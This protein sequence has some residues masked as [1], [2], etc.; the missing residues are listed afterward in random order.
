[1]AGK[2][3]MEKRKAKNLLDGSD[4]DEDIS[5]KINENYAQRYEKWRGKEEIQK[6]T[7]R[8]GENALKLDAPDDEDDSSSTDEDEDAKELT[9]DVEKQFFKTLACL[10]KKDPR[11]YD[12]NTRFFI[13]SGEAGESSEKGKKEKKEKPMFLRDYERKMLLETGG[14]GHISSDEEEDEP[15]RSASPTFVQ[16]QQEI[17][18]SFKDALRDYDEDDDGIAGLFKPK[19]KTDA[20]EEKEEEDY[21]LWLKGQ[22][23]ALENKEE[24]S[25]LGALKSYWTNPKLEEGEAFLRDYI[26]N[27]R[28]LG[29][30]ESKRKRPL[31]EMA[32]DSDESSGDEEMEEKMEMFEHK[33]NFRFEEPD[34]EFLKRYPR[35]MT[36]SLRNKDDRRKQHREELK[37]RKQREKEQKRQEL[38]QLKAIKR[39]EIE[40]RL[41]KLKE[42]TGNADIQF[43]GM[44]F[45]EDF[46]PEKHDKKMQSLFD[47]EFYH[48]GGEEEEK[49]EFPDL[50]KELELENWDEF[51]GDDGEGPSN[52]EVHCEDP[53]FNMDCDF[54]PKNKAFQQEMLENQTGRKKKKKRSKLAELLAKKKPS[55]DREKQ[56]IDKY[57]D[58]YYGLDY[59]DI[60]GDQPC[61]FKYR[62]V[63]PNS[64]GLTIEEILMADDKELNRWC[65]LKKTCQYRNE[66]KEYYDVQ[67]YGKKANLEELKRKIL[68]S[69]FKNEVEEENVIDEKPRKKKKKK[70]KKKAAN[71]IPEQEVQEPPENPDVQEML[72]EQ[73]IPESESLVKKSKLKKKKSANG[74]TLQNVPSENPKE[75]PEPL[76]Q[77][78]PKS[79][80]I[81][82]KPKLKRKNEGRPPSDEPKAKRPFKSKKRFSESK[83]S[84]VEDLSDARLKAYG[85][86][87]K[88]FKN[89]IK[90]SKKNQ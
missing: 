2:S 17:R 51:D 62:E 85:I 10:K 29:A 90:Y 20:E 28:Y 34:Q 65:S 44:D 15:D 63:V 66:D 41:S 80:S 8:Y 81:V 58:E 40:E 87:P 72:E 84:S 79:N 47:E 7:D 22:K 83:P 68:P 70:N 1:M 21:R 46:D 74:T 61:R 59:E 89:K 6:F 56:E 18:E 67:A 25:E 5:L 82:K 42:V 73:T 69:L 19:K 36:G 37:E 16:E 4:S 52:S 86:N 9:V 48:A 23:D 43:E 50:D 24:E 64:F 32:H 35:T 27:K 53:D 54:D 30:E 77:N 78:I 49:P 88:K 13:K 75:I 55:F 33:Y 26:L 3:S 76:K 71:G 39:K 57:M 11:I 60:V 45:D 12:A 14:R 38:K 31:A